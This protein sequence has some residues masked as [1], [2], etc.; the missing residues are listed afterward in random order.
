MRSQRL[1]AMK[2]WNKAEQRFGAGIR[3]ITAEQYEYAL[4]LDCVTCFAAGEAISDALRD[5]LAVA[6]KT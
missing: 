5:Q 4:V 3:T 6:C 2:G 1:K